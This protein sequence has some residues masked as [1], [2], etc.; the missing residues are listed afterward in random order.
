MIDYI[1]GVVDD[2]NPTTA[3]VEAGGVGYELTISLGT[4]TAIQGKEQVKL[5]WHMDDAWH[6]QMVDR[7]VIADTRDVVS[8]ASYG[9]P[10]TSEHKE[11]LVKYLSAYDFVNRRC[12]PRRAVAGGTAA[13]PADGAVHGDQAAAPGL[14]AV[15][16]DG[17]LLRAVLR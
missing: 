10:I 3:I 1:K 2:L 11:F 15:L 16:P 12:I 8:L 5:A 13:D 6:F 17:R 4:Y 9:L 7:K 14:P